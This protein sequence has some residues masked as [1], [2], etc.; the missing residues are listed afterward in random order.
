MSNPADDFLD[1]ALALPAADRAGVAAALLASLDEPSDDDAE[2]VEAAWV[3]ELETRAHRVL[4]GESAGRPWDE[5]R[6]EV[7]ARLRTT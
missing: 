5:V 1:A 2:Q 6:R 4:S 3:A 7:E